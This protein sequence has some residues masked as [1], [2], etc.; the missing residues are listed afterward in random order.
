ME[1]NKKIHFASLPYDVQK[2]RKNALET[3][4]KELIKY[5]EYNDFP[6]HLVDLYNNSS[7]HATCINAIVESIQGDGLTSDEPQTLEK[8]NADGESWND[9]FAKIAK[10]YYLFG[11]YALEI[12]YSKDRSKISSVYHIDFSYIRAKECDYRGNVPGYYISYEWEQNGKYQ[13]DYTKA[14]YIPSYNAS[15]RGEEPKQLL[16]FKPYQPQQRYYPLPSY[17]GALKVV[18]V[19]IQTDTFHNSNL[20]HGLTPS[21]AITTFTNATDEDRRAIESMLREQ[22]SGVHNSGQLLYMDVDDPANAP[23]I[24]PIPQNGGDDYYLSL[25]DSIVQK[26]LTA[27]RITSPMLLGIKTAGQLGGAQELL[28]AYTLFLNMVI[29]PYQ[30]DILKVFEKLIEAQSGLDITLGIEQ[31]QILDTGEEEVDVVTSKDAEGGD[32]VVLEENI[33]EQIEEAQD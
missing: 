9:I 26:I 3:S 5:G 20:A 21:L 1:E 14:T 2:P 29:K 7:I 4:E 8:A 10:D 24:E 18:E 25:N 15:R 11:G 12:I 13:V 16:Y 17:M 19:D 6:A 32:D 33:E 28:D 22:Y 23:K 30:Q 31:K 27:H